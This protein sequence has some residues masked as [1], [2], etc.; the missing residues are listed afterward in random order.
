RV[1]SRFGDEIEDE[2]RPHAVVAEAFPHFDEEQ[3]EQADRMSEPGFV[4]GEV[5]GLSR[6]SWGDSGHR[7]HFLN[8]WSGTSEQRPRTITHPARTSGGQLAPFSCVSPAGPTGSAPHR[9][10]SWFT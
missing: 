10:V 6:R 8:R 2:E 5:D 7:D 1:A 9:R 4:R 3:Q